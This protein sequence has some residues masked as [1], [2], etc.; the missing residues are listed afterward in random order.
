MLELRWD[1]NGEGEGRQQVY[2]YDSC[3]DIRPF[4]HYNI[5]HAR[6]KTLSLAMPW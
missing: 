3:R 2:I 4:P 1:R 5:L 6:Q